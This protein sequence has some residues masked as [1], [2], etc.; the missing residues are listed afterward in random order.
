MA[1]CSKNSRVQ[2]A[3]GL[4]DCPVI[5]L[6]DL[7]ELVALV[8]L[9]IWRHIFHVVPQLFGYLLHLLCGNLMLV[10]NIFLLF[11]HDISLIHHELLHGMQMVG[12]IFM[13]IFTVFF[14]CLHHPLIGNDVRIYYIP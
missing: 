7:T 9:E 10:D 8:V 13:T 14:L 12:A 6:H 11:F 1:P 5:L 4:A 3:S 2:G